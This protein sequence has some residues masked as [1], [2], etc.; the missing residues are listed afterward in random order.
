MQVFYESDFG[1]FL[2]GRI[3]ALAEEVRGEE[4]S[5]ILNVN[6]EEFITYLVG[7]YSLDIP[8][9]NRD[10]V[11]VDT[12]ER[13]IPAEQFPMTFNAY[14]GKSYPRQVIT[15]HVPFSGDLGLLRYTPSTRIMWTQEMDVVGSALAFDIVVFSQDSESLKRE[16][17]SVIDCLAQQL[18]YLRSE[19]EAFN[20][21][22]PEKARAA[23]DARRAEL[24]KRSSLLEGLGVPLKK[25]HDL[26]KTFAVPPPGQRRPIRP[27]AESL[28]RGKLE[29]ALD[30]S[31]Y[32]EILQTMWD[33]GTTMERL[34]STYTG[35][36]EETLRDHIL[37]YLTPRFEGSATGETFNKTGKTD[38]L[39]RYETSNVF[40]SECKFWSG[41]KGLIEGID[42]LL[43]YLTWRD[44][45][46]C[47]VIFVANQDFSAVLASIRQTVPTHPQ[48][49]RHVADHGESWFEYRLAL[50][51]DP[52]REIWLTILAF[53]LPPPD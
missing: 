39:L 48:F 20:G 34:P 44:S 37:L 29:P 25:R 22:L 21:S 30:A 33:L 51:G 47:L 15:Y 4:D 49:V 52:G 8:D 23:V 14:P 40:I 53:H 6:V 12:S 41:P 17:N 42:Q 13:M 46:A 9:L 38:I 32:L 24:L 27:Q 36:D 43:G 7:K 28:S 31:V 45:K 18:G 3:R 35:K 5:Y 10:E 26:P 50:P 2:D 19:G 16:A 11:F 1:Q